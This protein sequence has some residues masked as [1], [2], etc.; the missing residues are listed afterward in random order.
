MAHSDILPDHLRIPER[1]YRIASTRGVTVAATDFGRGDNDARPV[2]LMAHA[3][4]LHG[5]CWVPMVNALGERFRCIAID[6][7]AQGDS[8]VP[9]V[10]TLSW[11]GIADDIEISMGALGLLGRTDVYG[12][13]HSQGGF[14][15][16]ETERRRPGTF[17]GLFL[18][19]PVVMAFSDLGNASARVQ[20]DNH[21]ATIAERRRPVFASW[22]AAVENFS[23]KGPFAR[24]D[25]DLVA[26][27]VYWGFIEQPDGTIR[28]KCEPANEAGIFRNSITDLF[29]HV[30]PL[31]CPTTF[32]V[33]E[34][35]EPIFE[36]SGPQLAKSMPNG[37]LL[38]LPGRTHFGMFENI[39]EMANIMSNA[40]LGS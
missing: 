22:E 5:H 13:G 28:L 32:A 10:G 21:M 19:E 2:L 39:A 36:D 38:R 17:A 25:A 18:Y 20:Q 35:T 12:V 23:V 8:T 31:Q 29:D 24:A 30:G 9:T 15:V 33:S 7:R 6:Q 1:S 34:F 11:D 14:A 3:T 4:G 37:R 26:S 27:Y 16:L 40:L